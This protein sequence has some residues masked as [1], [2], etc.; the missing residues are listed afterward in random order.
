[1]VCKSYP[2]ECGRRKTR[3]R[4]LTKKTCQL[5]VMFALPN[6]WMVR[7]RIIL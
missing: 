1:M 3:Y 7:T 2:I 5:L 6:L 4:S